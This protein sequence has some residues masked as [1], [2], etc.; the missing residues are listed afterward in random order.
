LISLGKNEI[1][2]IIAK[3]GEVKVGCQFCDKEYVFNKEETDK[4]F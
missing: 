2:D 3:E 4:L 1:D